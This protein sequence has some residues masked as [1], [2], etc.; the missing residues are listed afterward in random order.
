MAQRVPEINI[1]QQNIIRALLNAHGKSTLAELADKTGLSSRIVRYNIDVVRSWLQCDEI[2]FINRPGYGVEVVASQQK[3]TELLDKINQLDDCDIVLSRQQRIRIILLYLLTSNE[4]VA[5]KKV[6][7]VEA[8]SRSTLFKDIIEIESWLEKYQI[9]LIRRSALGLWIDCSEE[10][11]RFALVRLIREELG[12]EN[13]YTL[14]KHF[15]TQSSYTNGSI[16]SRFTRFLNQLDLS[17]SQRLIQY[18]EENI[19]FSLSVISQT[20][21]MVYLAITVQSVLSGNTVTGNLDEDIIRSDEYAIAQAL[22]YQIEKRHSCQINDKEKEIIAALVKS[23]K[24]EPPDSPESQVT[25]TQYESSQSSEK[26]AQELINMCSMRLHP[27]IKI[28]DLLL[29]ELANHLD[30]AIFRLKHHIPIRNAHL[31]TLRERYSQIYRVAESSVF[32]LEN[33][34]QIPV[35]AEEV[36]FITMYLLS[37]LERLRTEEDARLTAVIAND[38]I[39]SKS[40][41]LK[42]RLQVEFPNLKITQ[43]INTFQ[44]IPDGG[45]NG[46]I[47]ISTVPVE[48]APLPVIEVSPFLEIEDIKN[49]QRWIAEKNQSRQRKGLDTLDQQNT[50]VDLIKLPHVTFMQNTTHWHEIVKAASAP[51]IA[52][53]CIQPRYIDAMIDLIENHGFYM[54]MGSGV[55]LLHAKPTDGVNQLCISLLKL[56]KPFH[57]TD[58]RIPDIDMIFVLGATD[59][60]SHLTALFQLNELIQFPKFMEA[61]RTSQTPQDIIQILWQWLPKLPEVA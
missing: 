14:Y 55:L 58:N 10:S 26:L 18:I 49:I 51:L 22:G 5:A 38:G 6:T 11:R 27:M 40:S 35:P 54:Y 28:D 31:K 57:F 59:D 53:R 30:Y 12:N 1:R 36:G 25:V 19:G 37:A 61:L 60:N 52:N 9:I 16:S 47:I 23:C 33:E 13:W 21:I 4:P 20:E 7:E 41:L 43:V 50:L 17:Y 24:L 45:I 3:K 42:S 2:E 34:I 29:N 8:F 15:H 39:R 32:L 44:G 56:S 46:E 48:N